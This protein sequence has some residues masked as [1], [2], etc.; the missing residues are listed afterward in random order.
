[1]IGDPDF[2]QVHAAWLDPRI[3]SGDEGRGIVAS[4]APSS[5][6]VGIRKN[7]GLSKSRY[8]GGSENPATIRKNQGAGIMTQRNAALLYRTAHGTSVAPRQLRAFEVRIY[9]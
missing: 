3:K 4:L 7:S 5:M 9:P 8:S 1:L 6:E 2:D